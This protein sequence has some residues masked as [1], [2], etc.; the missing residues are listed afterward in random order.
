MSAAQETGNKATVIRLL[1]AMNSSDAGLISQTVDEVFDPGV[2]QHTPF[3]RPG[4]KR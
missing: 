1:D 3:E 2:K 4:C